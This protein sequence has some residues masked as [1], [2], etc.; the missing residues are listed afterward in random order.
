MSMNLFDTPV[1]ALYSSPHGEVNCMMIASDVSRI[2]YPQNVIMIR[3]EDNAP[4]IVPEGYLNPLST[5]QGDVS[6]AQAEYRRDFQV[7]E[8]DHRPVGIYV[9]EMTEFDRAN[10]P[11]HLDECTCDDHDSDIAT[12]EEVDAHEQE[13]WE[14]RFNDPLY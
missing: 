14:K 13:Q 12:Q 1:P 2:D 6:E 5:K 10:P 11:Q 9:A 3:I 8:N 4:V 7:F